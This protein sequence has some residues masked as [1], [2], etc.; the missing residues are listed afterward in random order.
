MGDARIFVNLTEI[1]K[2]SEGPLRGRAGQR[3]RR[4]NVE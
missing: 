1:G 3:G 2:E 4:V